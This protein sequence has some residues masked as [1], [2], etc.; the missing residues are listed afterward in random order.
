MEFKENK[1]KSLLVVSDLKI[2]Y[3]IRKF[4]SIVGY[5][6]AVDGVSFS[7]KRGEIFSI[8]GES[9]CG[10]TTLGKGILRL[11]EPTHGKIFF[12]GK[13]VTHIK[14]KKLREYRR[15]TGIVQQDPYG[16]MPPFMSIK[17]ILEEPLRIHKVPKEERNEKI[18]KALEEVK[19]VPPEDF[20][21]KYPHMLSGGQLQRVAIARAFILDPKLVVADEPVSMLD[22]S[23]RVETLLLFKDLQKKHG[24]SV[25]YITHD[26]STTKYFSNRVGVMYAGHLVEVGLAKEVINNPKHP[27]TSHLIK[28]IP[29]P[30]PQNRFVLKK[31]LPGEPPSLVNPPKGCRLWPRCP[32]AMDICKQKE[33]PFIEVSPNHFVKCWLYARK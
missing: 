5:V 14:G 2:W 17:T 3:P 12:E 23:V 33:P 9:G 21:N 18:I 28:V 10:K 30:D 16:A 26:F 22:A 32:Y 7:V 8:V 25:I 20:L 27:Y 1:N 24:V 4:L 11:V 19:L 15:M 29:D 31:T 13:D 6:K